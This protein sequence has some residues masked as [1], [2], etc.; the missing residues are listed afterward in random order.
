MNEHITYIGLDVHKETISVALADGRGRK[1][2][3]D[4]GQIPNT[5][6][7]ITRLSRKL[8]ETGSVLRFC[9][10]AGPCGYGIHRQLSDAGHDC[11][12]VAPSLIPRKPG[13][14]IRTDRR[15]AINLAGLHRAGALTAVWGEGFP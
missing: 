7:A 1:A 4:H 5:P 3:L 10:E 6:A 14:R 8:S 11:A 13:D 2:V 9:Y 15:D 12:V